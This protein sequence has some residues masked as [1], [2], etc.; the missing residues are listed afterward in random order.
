MQFRILNQPAASA[1]E[2]Q[3]NNGERITTESGAMI[4]MTSGFHL[5]TTTHTRGG[6][7]LSKA[8]SDS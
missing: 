6:G 7:G 1:L 8:S 5:E 3:L 4:S 2:L